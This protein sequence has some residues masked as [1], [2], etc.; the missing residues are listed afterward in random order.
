MTDRTPSAQPSTAPAPA[1][2]G[3]R[4]DLLSLLPD[5]ATALLTSWGVPAYRE[6]QIFE[7]LMKA[8]TPEEMKNLPLS[9]RQMLTERCEIRLP[10][11]AAAQRSKKD[12]T[13]KYLFRLI[14]G[15]CVESVLMKYAYGYTICISSQVGCRM[16][17]RFCASTISGRV[18]DLTPSE[19][20][21]QILAARADSGAAVTRVVMMGI[22][23]PLDNYDN[24]LR[25]LR[26]ASHPQRL[27]ISPR[28]VSL[29]TCGVVPRILDLAREEI[30]VTLSVSLHASD[31]EARSAIMPVNRKWPIAELLAACRTY[32]RATGRRI[33]FEYT[34]L[35]GV[36]DSP[37]DARRLASVLRAGLGDMPV[38]VNLIRLNPVA[39]RTYRTPAAASAQAFADTLARADVT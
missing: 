7:W 25:F 20:L 16:G 30:P 38:H 17:C 22:G 23:E 6:K 14:D 36:N 5:E 29:S 26:L 2:P 34:L 35:S 4:V 13:V 32:F 28:R 39:E 18:R 24:V 3:G 15:A 21:G 27:G 1:A 12:G 19:M 11:V 10:T 33:S 37:A 9:L 8:K 31:D